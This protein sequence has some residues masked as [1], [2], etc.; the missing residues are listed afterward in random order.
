VSWLLIVLEF[1]VLLVHISI[2]GHSSSVSLALSWQFGP[3]EDIRPQGV[4]LESVLDSGVDLG[5]LLPFQGQSSL[6]LFGF[7]SVMADMDGVLSLFQAQRHLPGVD[8]VP[9]AVSLDLIEQ[10]TQSVH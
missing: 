8:E 2:V 6:D 9:Q 5:A 7:A 10:V 4:Q 1:L 3:S